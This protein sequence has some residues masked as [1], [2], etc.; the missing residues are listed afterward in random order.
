MRQLKDLKINI[1]NKSVDDSLII[2]K[3][4]NRFLANQ[5]I[6]EI[7]KIR[8]MKIFYRDSLVNNMS[9]D[10]FGSSTP[11]DQLS[12]YYSEHVDSSDINEYSDLIIVC[13]EIDNLRDDIDS[14]IYELP[15]LENQ[16][17]D[18]YVVAR[19][20]TVPLSKLLWLN[21]ISNYNIYRIQNELDKILLFTEA[22]R[23]EIF[24]MMIEQ[25]SFDDLSNQSIFNF[26]NALLSKDI[27]VISQVMREIENIDIEPIGLITIMH[28]N[29]KNLIA[30][31]NNS[32]EAIGLNSKQ[33][34]A[35]SH[36]KTP[37]TLK[38]LEALLIYI[39]ELD[40]GI[41]NGDIDINNII[42][43]I[44]CKFLTI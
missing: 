37:F 31:R 12:V 8:N 13:E 43:L 1:M 11:S 40:Y 35:L 14:F 25:G 28:K 34:Y 44:T 21:S 32:G 4:K 38:N 19:D 22:H 18:D 29:L 20:K 9:D 16:H 41:K 10:L 6:D 30:V 24:D 23:E 42:N 3:G 26:T 27:N 15:N 5:Y 2:F 33:I 7:S 17:I 36:I 39:N